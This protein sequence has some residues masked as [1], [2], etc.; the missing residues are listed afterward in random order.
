MGVRTKPFCPVCFKEADSSTCPYCAT[1]LNSH[2]RPLKADTLTIL[3]DNVRQFQNDQPM[4][5]RALWEIANYWMRLGRWRMA[6]LYLESV[7]TVGEKAGRPAFLAAVQRQLGALLIKMGEEVAGKNLLQLAHEAGD[8]AVKREW[9]R[10]AIDARDFDRAKQLAHEVEAVPYF[11]LEAQAWRAEILARQG[12]AQ[13][14]EWATLTL[15]AAIDQDSDISI[16]L[17]RRALS[18]VAKDYKEARQSGEQAIDFF[19][20]IHDP[21]EVAQTRYDMARISLRYGDTHYARTS[22][23][24]AATRFLQM[25]AIPA[26]NR[27]WDFLK[28]LP[29]DELEQLAS[30]DA[31]ATHTAV[32]LLTVQLNGSWAEEIPKLLCEVATRQGG[33]CDS[34]GDRLLVLFG[35]DQRNRE[36]VVET[37]LAFYEILKPLTDQSRRERQRN[38]MAFRIAAATGMLPYEEHDLPRSLDIISKAG[39]YKQAQLQMSQAPSDYIIV[40]DA[41]YLQTEARYEYT[42][43]KTN[44]TSQWWSLVTPYQHIQSNILPNRAALSSEYEVV[45]QEVD[46][47]LNR[48]IEQ[49]QGG[50][51]VLE[52]LAGAGKTRLLDVLRAEIRSSVPAM[53]IQLRGHADTRYEPF[54]ALREWLGTEIP[55]SVYEP[56]ERQRAYL[57]AFHMSLTGMLKTRPV[58]LIIDDIHLIDSASLQA[59]QAIFPLMARHPLMVIVTARPEGNL[60]W[61]KLVQRVQRALPENSVRVL[62]PTLASPPREY[63]ETEDITARWVLECAAVLGREFPVRVL[64]RM[65][66]VPDLTR[67]LV[68]FGLNKYLIPTDE[69]LVWR[70]AYSSEWETLYRKLEPQHLQR[71]HSYAWAALHSMAMPADRHA[72][73]A[74]L[75]QIALPVLLQKLA[76]V[77]S[78][79]APEEALLYYDAALA[80]HPTPAISLNLL[81]GR[82]EMLLQMGQLNPAEQTLRTIYR[83]QSMNEEQ[84]VRL[85]YFEGELLRQLGEISGL[86]RLYSNAM[87]ALRSDAPSANLINTQ[88]EVLYAQA[89]A[90]FQ[91]EDVEVAK[92]LIG[93]AIFK[94]E[95]ADL[96]YQLVRLWQLL[97]R[98]H[99]GRANY[100]QAWQAA[101]RALEVQE[102]LGFRFCTAETHLLA[103]NLQEMMG[104]LRKAREHYLHALNRFEDMGNVDSI[105]HV[106]LRLAM[107]AMYEGQFDYVSEQLEAAIKIAPFS[108]SIMLRVQLYSA[109][110]EGLALKGDLVSAFQQANLGLELAKQFSNK[111]ALSEGYIALAK[112][113]REAKWWVAAR[114]AI[115]H[116]MRLIPQNVYPLL[117]LRAYVTL[118]D[119]LLATH[120]I[121]G[122]VKVYNMTRDIGTAPGDELVRARLH[123]LVG[124]YR[125]LQD[126]P[127][128]AA[129]EVEKAY[130]QLSRMGAAYWLDEARELLREINEQFNADVS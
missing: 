33:M 100:T 125:L 91:N 55:I 40:D 103:G 46:R 60:K 2:R 45:L 87:A 49:K 92:S 3:T 5:M 124:R 70:F 113:A 106:R 16:A 24:E 101:R 34:V 110:A 76:Q 51:V 7:L 123:L 28:S 58:L 37:A 107:L 126:N 18:V 25:G 59:L 109:Y 117:R 1:Q 129:V 20:R 104:N 63:A 118:M 93:T 111:L 84:R 17:T 53:L 94:A 11:Q 112:A 120:Q 47:V 98:L 9:L 50:L 68:E 67:Y 119:I 83:S 48:F 97:A 21:Y 38:P 90:H 130:R 36:M 77:R 42:L 128:M 15:L 30:K 85:M 114:D 54:G 115:E 95:Q 27:A 10:M 31:S 19:R 96:P 43:L 122:F 52:G 108:E 80:H 61:Q 13:A 127:N 35:T 69:P 41:I 56:Q 75:H 6:R 23:G 32:A 12:D 22:L 62:L 88:I 99:Q 86:F 57:T 26:Y 89:M 73:L 105:L 44:T 4:L 71:L 39:F 82:V 14:S 29:V 66:G 74:N 81:I 64:R 8:A 102:K 65:A 78:F 79:D 72:H 116:A 121:E